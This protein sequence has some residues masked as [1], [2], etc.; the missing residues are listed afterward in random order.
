[1]GPCRGSRRSDWLPFDRLRD[2]EPGRGVKPFDK[3][4]P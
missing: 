2:P 1:M 3:L 4:R